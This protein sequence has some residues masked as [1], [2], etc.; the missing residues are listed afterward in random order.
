MNPY[1]ISIKGSD[2]PEA[3]AF[4]IMMHA[5]Y[6]DWTVMNATRAAAKSKNAAAAAVQSSSS[7]VWVWG[8][9]CIGAFL[10]CILL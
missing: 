1:N 8:S 2:S 4:V 5:A 3:E 7:V 9:L 6:R 10:H